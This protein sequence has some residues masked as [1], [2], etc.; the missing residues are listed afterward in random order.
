MSVNK[1]QRAAIAEV[2][3]RLERDF[4]GRG[5]SSVRVSTSGG[6]PEVVT[7]LSLDTLTAAD[8]TLVERGAV[9]SVVE[10]H[11]ALHLATR[12]EFVDEVGGIVGRRPEAYFAQVDPDTGYALRVFVF[13]D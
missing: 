2:V 3:T 6:V 9:A 11:V 5:P 7:V 4:Y 12:D 13:D 8:R 1:E 10:H